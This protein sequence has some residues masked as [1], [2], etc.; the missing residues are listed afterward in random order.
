MAYN[1]AQVDLSNSSWKIPT[2]KKIVNQVDENDKIEN[3]VKNQIGLNYAI[4]K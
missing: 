1:V 3:F 4:F 2:P